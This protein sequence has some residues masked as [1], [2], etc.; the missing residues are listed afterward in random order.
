MNRFNR[1]KYGAIMLLLLLALPSQIYAYSA[2]LISK[3]KITKL[4]P[5][6]QMFE[7]LSYK[8]SWVG[9]KQKVEIQKGEEKFSV[10]TKLEASEFS[11]SNNLKGVLINGTAYMYIEDLE[12]V[13]FAYD[14]ISGDTVDIYKI[15]GKG[16]LAPIIESTKLSK[17][18]KDILNDTKK[19]KAV[20]FWAT[21]CPYCTKYM[22]ELEELGN[23]SAL[24]TDYQFVGINIDQLEKQEDAKM[25]IEDSGLNIKSVFDPDKEIMNHYRPNVIPT[26]YFI[27]QDG[28]IEDIVEGSI[29]K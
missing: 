28:I 26:T 6:R 25:V 11:E 9:E 10:S 2:Q 7:D 17:E 12:R 21:W 22:E 5:I 19:K 14:I 18:Q 23:E 24:F 4:L 1:I 13:G 3:P 20:F 29:I 16:D 8:V 27:N 15:V